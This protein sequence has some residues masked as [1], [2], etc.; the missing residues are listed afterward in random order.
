MLSLEQSQQDASVITHST[1]RI[2]Q[3]HQRNYC[4]ILEVHHLSN[5]PLLRVTHSLCLP[6]NSNQIFAQPLYNLFTRLASRT[7]FND[8]VDD[9]SILSY[10][11]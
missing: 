6:K 7:C 4:S 1:R 5:Q 9:S 3:Q 8:A 2:R 11:L 10:F